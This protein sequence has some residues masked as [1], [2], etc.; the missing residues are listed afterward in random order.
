M[1]IQ[2]I[3]SLESWEAAQVFRE[4]RDVSTLCAQASRF[5][6]EEGCRA[7]VCLCEPSCNACMGY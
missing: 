7:N 4:L 6:K 5:H 2:K 1:I 3:T